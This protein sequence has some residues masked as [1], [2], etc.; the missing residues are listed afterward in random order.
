MCSV[1]LSNTSIAKNK[2][3]WRQ[4][5]HKIAKA[6]SIFETG[7]RAYKNL[8]VYDNRGAATQGAYFT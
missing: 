5:N 3:Y 8:S 4:K 6:D 7:A 2:F 1:A